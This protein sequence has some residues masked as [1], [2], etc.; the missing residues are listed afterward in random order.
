MRGG[1]F[2]GAM[3]AL[4]VFASLVLAAGAFGNDLTLTSIQSGSNTTPVHDRGIHGEGQIIAV[5]DTGADW[6]NC[7]LAEPDGSRP[8]LNTGTPSGGL[9]W[10]NI[11]L[12]RRKIIAYNLLYSCDQF[13]GAFGCDNPSLPQ[14]YT[15]TSNAF[16]NQGHGT[17]AAT[18]AAGDKLTPIAHDSGDSIAP[19][20][21]LVVQDGGAIFSGG[22]LLGDNCSHRPGFG[23][24]VNLT[25]ILDQAYKQG[26]RIHSNSWGD[27]QG[28]P[29]SLPAPTANYSQ[30]ARDVDAFVWAHP[31][32][33]V[34]FNTGNLGN[35]NGSLNEGDMAPA[36]S[37]SAPGSAKNTLQVGGV[38][39]YEGQSDTQ[40]ANYSLIGP[41]RDGRIKPDLVAPAHVLA[42]DASVYAKN[43]CTASGQPGTSWSSPTVAGAAA[44]VRQYFTDGFYP[45]GAASPSSRIIPSA[46]LLKATLIAAT[47][48]VPYRSTRSSRFDAEPV[49][50]Y[51]QG[52]GFPVLDDALYFSGDRRR[53][54]VHDVPLATGLA[55]G[56]TFSTTVKARAGTQFKA[57]LVWTDPPGHVAGVSDTSMQL[58]NDLDLRVTAPGDVSIVGNHSLTSGQADRLNNVEA[59]T[60]EAPAAGTYTITV[61][62]PRLGMGPRQSFSLVL[63]GDFESDPVRRRSVRR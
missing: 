24:P 8:P 60:I 31:D 14:D 10:Q 48:A 3:R 20:A 39:G 37:L 51:E 54:R 35:A 41:T 26:A 18:T 2:L 61:S 6:T 57:V 25:P 32:M 17:H 13:P 12:S 33:L 27:R 56:E 11:D 23:C 42:G 19:A 43:S 38:R 44:L 9:D 45:G 63:T 62:A 7:Y 1:V 21:K 55:Q 34:V 16:D 46:A 52:F 4:T 22:V 36:S 30:S 53:L 47:R 50:S 15:S 40:I 58:V 49:P 29:S 5:L 59:V 28:T